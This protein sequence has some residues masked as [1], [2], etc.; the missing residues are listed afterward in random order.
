MASIFGMK[1]P[2]PDPAMQKAQRKQSKAI[3][4]QTAEEAQELGARNRLLHAARLGGGLFSHT[5]GAGV[6][7]TLG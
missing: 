4:D 6:R 1:T 2:K 3:E 7:D 5:G